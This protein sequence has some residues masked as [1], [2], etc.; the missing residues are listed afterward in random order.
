VKP[1]NQWF[2]L[3]G[4][5]FVSLSACSTRER[6]TEPKGSQLF[7]RLSEGDY[8]SSTYIE[9]LK[10]TRSPFEAGKTGRINLVVV[11]RKGSKLLLE[12]IFDFH[13]SGVMFAVHDDG[14]A[15][16][17][18]PCGEDTRN[19]TASVVDELT[20]RF[21]FGELEPVTYV[22]VNNSSEY[23]SRAALV[24]K[25]YDRQ[26]RTYEFYA[27]WLGDFSRSQIQV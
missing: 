7:V 15:P 4:L 24:G 14:A 10:R 9:T 26:R 8:L 23:I 21:G 16:C 27:R 5:F 6:V 20:L 12:P 18:E 22:F 1:A 3:L 25:Y 11:Q 13:E 19:L 17:L 2:V